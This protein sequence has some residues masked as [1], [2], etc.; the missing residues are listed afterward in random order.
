MVTSV[1]NIAGVEIFERYPFTRNYI[2]EINE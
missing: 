1:K 2:I